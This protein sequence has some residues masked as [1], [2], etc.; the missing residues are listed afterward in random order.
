M[1]GSAI[2]TSERNLRFTVDSRRPAKR[3]G[4]WTEEW[5]LIER[6]ERSP[7]WTAS[8]FFDVTASSFEELSPV[9]SLEANRPRWPRPRPP[10]AG[11]DRVVDEVSGA[12]PLPAPPSLGKSTGSE[13]TEALEAV[14]SRTGTLRLDFPEETFAGFERVLGLD[15]FTLAL[16]STPL[17]NLCKNG[18]IHS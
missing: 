9:F 10:P 12:T 17:A 6:L 11:A 13:T 4:E 8:L 16:N 5:D 1:A 2:G 3:M 18:P 14:F 15:N 7:A